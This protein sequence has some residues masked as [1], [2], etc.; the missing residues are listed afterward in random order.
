MSSRPDPRLDPAA[1][2]G[3]SPALVAA[4]RRLLRPLVHL[5]V[6]RGITYPQLS[7]LLK[8]LFVEVADGD[9]RLDGKAPT[10]SRVSLVSGVHRKD[11]S[12]LRPLL[13]TPGAPEFLLLPKQSP[14]ASALGEG[15]RQAGA[16]DMLDYVRQLA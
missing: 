16:P 3:P 5:M 13:R 11:V 15:L 4:L 14:Q 7:D 6:A 8:G 1:A 9:F 12:R 10:D 2:A